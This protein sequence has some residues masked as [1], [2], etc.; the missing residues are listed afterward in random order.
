MTKRRL[1]LSWIGHADLWAM[2]D[3]LGDAGKQLLAKAKITGKYGEKP[4]PLKSA[5]DSGLFHEIHLLSNYPV[6][7]H[8]PFAQW[9]GAKP[10]IHAVEL[11]DPT[12]YSKVFEAADSVLSNVANR[13]KNRAER[14]LAILLSPGTPAIVDGS[15]RGSQIEE[16][17]TRARLHGAT[18]PA[19]FPLRRGHHDRNSLM[20][21]GAPLALSRSRSSHHALPFSIRWISVMT[22]TSMAVSIDLPLSMGWGSASV[23]TAWYVWMYSIS[24]LALDL[25]RRN[26]VRPTCIA[27]GRNER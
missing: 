14:E 24:P 18:R 21:V 13:D 16:F 4:G 10:T 15:F 8:K 27:I 20:R 26:C 5:V 23:P 2:A 1:L 7:I 6:A 22:L 11:A 19:V 17:R 9:L 12:D 3:D 25:W